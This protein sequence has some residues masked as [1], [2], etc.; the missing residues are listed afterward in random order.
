[1]IIAANFIL[2]IRDLKLRSKIYD[3]VDLFEKFELI[4]QFVGFTFA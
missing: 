4:F 1:V 2:E 3:P